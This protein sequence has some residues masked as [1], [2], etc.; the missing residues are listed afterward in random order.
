M[1]FGLLSIISYTLFAYNL[2]RTQS[3][4]LIF[5][6]LALF[7][8]AYKLTQINSNFKL[9][10]TLGIL[11]RLVFLFALPNLSQDFYRF[12]WDGR[13]L[14]NGINP[15]LYLP[16]T[17]ITEKTEVVYQSKL[18]Y[19]GM[20]V[21]NGSHYSNYPPLNQLCFAVAAL[22]AGKSILGSVVVMR[23]LIILADIGIVFYGKKILAYFNLPTKR[24]FWYF[25]N[26]FIIIELTGNLHFESVMLF[27]FVVSFYLLSKSKW[28]WAAFAFSA[29]IL[30]KLIPLLG[31]PL[32]FWYFL[33]T[34]LGV[35]RLIGFYLIILLTCLLMFAPFYTQIFIDN[36]TETISL[37]FNNFEFNASFYYL[38][39]AVGYYFRGYN[40]IQII[41]KIISILV[42]V[43]VFMMTFLRNN[44]SLPK[45]MSTLLLCFSFYYFTSTTVHPWYL[46]TLVLLS[47]FTKYRFP[48]IWVAVVVLSYLTYNPVYKPYNYWVFGIEYAVVFTV[49]LWDLVRCYPKKCIKKHIEK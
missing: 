23:L 7:F 32:L 9:L 29:S 1:P 26:P 35:W 49:F 18:L 22:F 42:I 27:F 6:W 8:F 46:A 12:I 43:F 10:F 15:Y 40:E 25:L 3:L 17:F 14:L 33:K 37:W 41:G 21:S 13:M 36:Y 45:L 16:E 20:G 31:L 44:N 28:I 38:L 2:E 30:V 24:V 11:F 47:V 48:L 19:Q 39:R 34:K 4:K 5:L